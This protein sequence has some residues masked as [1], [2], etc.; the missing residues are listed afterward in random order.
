M[1]CVTLVWK[2][3]TWRVEDESVLDGVTLPPESEE[4]A[5]YAE[6]LRWEVVDPNGEVVHSGVGQDPRV[7]F[8]DHLTKEGELEGGQFTHDFAVI[9]VL[10]PDRP[11]AELRLHAAHP[12]ARGGPVKGLD[13]ALTHRI[14]GPRG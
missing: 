8:Y 6:W 14:G 10:V 2:D 11:G 12:D 7:G 1:R 13:V 5:E 4:G 3:Q 9:D